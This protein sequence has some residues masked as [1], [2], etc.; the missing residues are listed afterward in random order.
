MRQASEHLTPVTLELGGKS[1]CLIEESAHIDL[2]AKRCAW[3]KFLNAGQTCVAPDYVLIPRIFQDEFIERIKFHLKSFYGDAEKSVDYS[4]IIN[5]K[6]FDRLIN[7]IDPE[8]VVSGGQFSKEKMYIAPTVLKDVS[9]SDHVMLEEIFG[10]ILPIIPYDDLDDVLNKMM[11]LPKPLAFYLFSTNA[12]R[13]KDLMHR[14]P[15]GGGCINDTILHLSNAA[16]PFG[17][18]GSSG[19]GSYH[20]KK[21]FD[22]FTHYKS[23][24]YQNNYWDIPLRYP[25]HEGKLG[26]LKFFFR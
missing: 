23:V 9:W 6:H 22:T 26:W 1:P 8:K 25:P 21:T 3:G 12:Q 13:I 16:L 15:F 7:L 19:M 4:R 17:G 10:P 18:V 11:L 2:A 24:F 20:G 5:E 14:V